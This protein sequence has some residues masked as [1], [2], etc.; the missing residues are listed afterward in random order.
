[1]LIT[2]EYL[3]LNI[4]LLLAVLQVI[5]GTKRVCYYG[6]WSARKNLQPD[7]I[8]ASLCTHLIFAYA[9]LDANFT[10]LIPETTFEGTQLTLFTNLKQRNPALKTL[11][12]LGGWKMGSRPFIMLVSNEATM[13]T[14]AANTIKFLRVHGFDGL[15]VDWEFP[16]QRGSEIE[17]KAN[18]I[19]LLKILHDAFVN[20]PN[21]AGRERLM[22]T[23]AVG[24]A[25]K[26]VTQSYDVPGLIQY[27]D[28]I[29]LITYDFHGEWEETVNVHNALYSD[30]DESVDRSV[31]YWLS[32]GV[33]K[34]KLLVGV[35]LYGRKFLLNDQL[36]N[37]IG[38]PSSGGGDMPF[39]EICEMIQSHKIAPVRLQQERVPYFFYQSQWITYEDTRSITEKAAYIRTQG[40]AGVMVWAVNLD[41]YI[42]VCHS[43]KFPL[44]KALKKGLEEQVV[45][46]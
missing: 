28:W 33:P 42:G 24:P 9:D 34:D 21:R 15:D 39:Y 5:Y 4:V 46:G 27:L 10:N 2:G 1:M 20:E 30:N 29:G 32:L 40:V 7:D 13:H 23:A 43:G 18:F 3:V 22:L 14:F 45:V 38:A 12:S 6:A 8:D 35:P 26:L 36:N 19:M 17:D 37:T 44:L 16:N 11:I 31:Q 41:D 25:E